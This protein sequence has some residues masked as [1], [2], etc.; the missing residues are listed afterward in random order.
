ML[1]ASAMLAAGNASAICHWEW[2]CNGE[3][4]CR[5]MPVCDTLYE[6]P[7]PKPEAAPPTAPTGL[8][9]QKIPNSMGQADCEFVQRQDETGQWHWDQACYCS[10][11]TK[12]RDGSTPMS[13][14]VRCDAPVK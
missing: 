14:I 3:G 6:T 11:I 10:D 9:P 12:G 4:G 5:Q 7:P 13:N 2:L 1:A 8:R